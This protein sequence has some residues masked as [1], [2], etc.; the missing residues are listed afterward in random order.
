MIDVHSHILPGLDDG[1]R[2]MDDA[3]R[4]ARDAVADGTRVMVTTP[5]VDHPQFH[6]EEAASSAALAA[7]RDRLA[8]EEIPLALVAGAEVTFSERTH[9]RVEERRLPVIGG[10]P[11]VLLEL[12]DPLPPGL[13]EELFHCRLNGYQVVLAHV[14][15][16]R[17][18]Q[19][20]ADVV[21]RW[22]DQGLH[23]QVTAQSVLGEMGERCERSARELLERR[24][25]HVLASDA[26]NPARRP[27]GLARAAEAAAEILGSE[28]EARAL[29]EG[30][31]GR[32]VS[33]ESLDVARP[34]PPARSWISR[35]M[36]G[37]R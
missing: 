14:E 30:N 35:L 32:I 24:L 20:S 11:F 22:I 3:L 28:E 2:S 26:H 34:R 5:H 29:V 6:V 36:G 17:A 27:P 10:G 16:L 33:G 19:A 4:M 37:T 12:Y 31:P 13:D 9:A 21:A 7:L 1:A 15:R 25:V 23:P 8:A 18:V